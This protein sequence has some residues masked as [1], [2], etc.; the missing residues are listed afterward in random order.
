VW[1]NTF[2]GAR[3]NMVLRPWAEP[4][5]TE[6]QAAHA[7]EGR[8]FFNEEPKPEHYKPYPFRILNPCS[9]TSFPKQKVKAEY[10]TVLKIDQHFAGG[11]TAGVS[12]GFAPTMIIDRWH[13]YFG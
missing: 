12:H 6:K 11:R 4:D 1:N 5:K 13:E 10:C 7:K 9:S 2:N 3:L 8:D